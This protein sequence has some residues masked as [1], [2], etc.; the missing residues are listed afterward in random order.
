MDYR[1]CLTQKEKA[2]VFKDRMKAGEDELLSLQSEIHQYITAYE[3]INCRQGSILHQVMPLKCD[4]ATKFWVEDRAL[5]GSPKV[6]LQQVG[7]KADNF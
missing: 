3:Q 6:F 1:L 5:F 2:S 4:D 7:R